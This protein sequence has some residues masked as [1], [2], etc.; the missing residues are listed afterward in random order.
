[1]LLRQL[2]SCRVMACVFVQCRFSLEFMQKITE[3]S[4]CKMKERECW[5]VQTLEERRRERMDELF[6]YCAHVRVYKYRLSE[7]REGWRRG[8]K[9]RPWSVL[10]PHLFFICCTIQSMPWNSLGKQIEVK[11]RVIKGSTIF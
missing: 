8:V 11:K 2:I 9:E 7:G 6:I 1:M 5:H 3:I 10:L 4:V